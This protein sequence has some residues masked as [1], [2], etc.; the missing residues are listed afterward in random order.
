MEDGER[1]ERLRGRKLDALWLVE[2]LAVPYSFRR[3]LL[4]GT[5]R[6]GER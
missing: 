2:K 5:Q 1:Q 6:Q 3:T 4:C